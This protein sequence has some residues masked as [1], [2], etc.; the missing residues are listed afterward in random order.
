M[1]Q[2][3]QTFQLVAEEIKSVRIDI[4]YLNRKVSKHDMGI[5]NLNQRF[6]Q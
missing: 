5:N 4:D 6:Q 1:E 2:H 3:Q